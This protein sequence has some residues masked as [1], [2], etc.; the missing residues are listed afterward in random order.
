MAYHCVYDLFRLGQ[1]DKI[2]S[3]T[4]VG[5][6]MR[7]IDLDPD[8]VV[9]LKGRLYNVFSHDD[10]LMR[11]LLVQRSDGSEHEP[12]GLRKFSAED[13]IKNL[14]LPFEIGR[15][16]KLVRNLDLSQWVKSHAQFKFHLKD[17]LDFVRFSLPYDLLVSRIGALST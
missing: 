14:T 3:L 13:F 4:L 7:V 12:V 6:P 9:N 5:S 11:Y 15:D 16:V 1:M 10:F 2:A 17:I 8:I